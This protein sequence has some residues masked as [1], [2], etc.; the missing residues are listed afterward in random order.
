MD[1]CT[2]HP[3]AVARGMFR[4][5]GGVTEPAPAPRFS[6]TACAPGNPPPDARAATSATLADWGIA[7]GRI[8]ELARNGVIAS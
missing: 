8:A 7:A 4:H 2:T 5:E 1:E 6:R 3:L